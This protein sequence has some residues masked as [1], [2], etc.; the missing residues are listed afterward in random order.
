MN[1]V[2]SSHIRSHRQLDD[3][4][5]PPAGRHRRTPAAP[6]RRRRAIGRT[7]VMIGIMLAVGGTGVAW[8]AWSSTG[9]GSATAAAGTAQA[10][11]TTSVS[12]AAITTGL[13]YPG[14]PAGAVT[15]TVNNPNPYAVVVTLVAGDGAVTASGGL[16]TCSTTGV[17]FTAQNP[18]SDNAVAANGSATLTLAGAATMGTASETGCQSAVFTIPVTVTIASG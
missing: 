17:G 9:T 4:F 11:T 13:L 2:D 7:A 18:S 8:A 15:L 12:G 10:P 16:G 14:G 6:R 5:T 3:E 1:Q